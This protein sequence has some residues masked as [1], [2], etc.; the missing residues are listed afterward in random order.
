MLCH[1]VVEVVELVVQV[2]EIQE[3][4]RDLEEMDIHSQ[5]FLLLL[6]NQH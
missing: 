4:T 6:L 3:H 5:S 2:Q 1:L